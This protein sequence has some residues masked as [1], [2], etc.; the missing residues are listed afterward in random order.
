[1]LGLSVDFCWLSCTSSAEQAQRTLNDMARIEETFT[2]FMLV[3]F[4]M[5]NHS[6]L[7]RFKREF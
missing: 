4:D 5:R 1:M 2:L 6:Y 7:A 3:K